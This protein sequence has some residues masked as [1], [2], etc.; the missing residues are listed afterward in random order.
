M[1][2]KE[3]EARSKMVTIEEKTL[4]DKKGKTT[5]AEVKNETS[6][7]AFHEGSNPARKEITMPSSSESEWD[8]YF[9]VSR[10]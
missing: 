5:Q 8:E 2:Q 1:Q 10:G 3:G 9:M 7:A 6:S 4:N